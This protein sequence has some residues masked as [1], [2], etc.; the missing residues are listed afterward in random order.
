[1]PKFTRA[2]VVEIF[3]SLGFSGAGKWKK[4]RLHGRVLSLPKSMT[5]E[6]LGDDDLDRLVQELI[7]CV[8]DG[9]EIEIVQDDEEAAEDV[10][11]DESETPLTKAKKKGKKSK[12]PEYEDVEDD[13]EEATAEDDV[14]EEVAVTKKAKPAKTKPAKSKT[15]KD[16][17]V[18]N[19]PGV[20][21]SIIEILQGTSKKNAVT[22]DDV[23][24]Q[25]IER[26]PDRPEKGMRSTVQTQVRYRLPKQYNVQAADGRYWIAK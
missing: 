8:K 23:V 6:S 17:P 15:K 22:I 19:K 11:K 4:E 2:S 3:E 13:E 16:G 14:V 10:V 1:M 9:D 25:L 21:T 24:S 20:I 7:Q 26:F 12:E 5:D 18:K